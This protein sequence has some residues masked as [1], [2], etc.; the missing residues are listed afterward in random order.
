M[1]NNLLLKVYIIISGWVFFSV[2][3]LH[4]L[5][6]IY[7]TPVVVGTISIPMFLSYLGLAGSI[8]IIILALYLLRKLFLLK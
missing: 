1:K 6:L 8:G 4:L 2:G 3:L 5:R 7:Q